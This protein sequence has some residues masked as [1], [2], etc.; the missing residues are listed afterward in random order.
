MESSNT[1]AVEVTSINID[2]RSMHNL[3]AIGYK[4]ESFRK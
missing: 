3:Q 2:Y 1:N 4:K